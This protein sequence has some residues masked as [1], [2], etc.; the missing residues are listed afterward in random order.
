MVTFVKLSYGFCLHIWWYREYMSFYS[1]VKSSFPKFKAALSNKLVKVSGKH[2]MSVSSAASVW[3][4]KSLFSALSSSIYAS[5]LR[6][7]YAFFIK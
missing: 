4:H 6:L 1:E 3:D 5:K 7:C 2:V